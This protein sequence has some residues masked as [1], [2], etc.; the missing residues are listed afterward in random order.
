MA[1]RNSKS[2]S[3]DSEMTSDSRFGQYLQKHGSGLSGSSSD[4]SMRLPN[5]LNVKDVKWLQ[6]RCET[7]SNLTLDTVATGENVQ[8]RALVEQYP[9]TEASVALWW[10]I[11]KDFEQV[12]KLCAFADLGWKEDDLTK[13]AVWIRMKDM[14]GSEMVNMIMWW[15][16]GRKFN[17]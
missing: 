5:V 2:V 9:V 15:H 13:S 3:T 4:S 17:A 11:L 6:N 1:A 10:M 12:R 16:E 7:P 14:T 8:L